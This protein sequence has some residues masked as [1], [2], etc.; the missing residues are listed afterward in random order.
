MKTNTLTT[1]YK[2]EPVARLVKRD[3]SGPLYRMLV[4]VGAIVIAFFCIAGFVGIVTDFSFSK[5]VE[6]IF[7]GVMG[8]KITTDSWLKDASFL[9]LIGLALAPAFKMKFWNI[10]AQGQVLVGALMTAI[11]MVNFSAA[12][13]NGS[14]ILVSFVLSILA[15]GIWALIPAFFKIKLNANETLFTLMLNYIAIQLVASCINMWRGQNSALGTLNP[16]TQSG[17]LPDMF[18]NPYGI[19]F[20]AAV[21]F[22]VLIYIYMYKTKHGYEISVV[23]ESINTARYAGINTKKVILRTMFLS[24]AIAGLCGF[25]YVAGINHSIA[26]NTGGSYGFTAIIVAWASKFNPFAM[27]AISLLIVFVEKGS[28]GIINA[29]KSLNNSIIYINVA[30]FLLFLIGCEFFINYKIVFNSRIVALIAKSKADIQKKLPKTCAFFGKTV[31]FFKKL[32]AKIQ[33]RCDEIAN[34]AE[35]LVKSAAL[36]VKDA[37]LKQKNKIAARLPHKSKKI[38]SKKEAE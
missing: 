29:E 2:R 6:L 4:R 9:L 26:A 15:G 8:T 31:N 20:F 23:G 12:L 34:H 18:G 33:D 22:M 11:A 30:I 13:D 19:V 35:R 36:P 14:L 25:I 16:S 24:G 7:D 5:I 37:I 27:A 3:D 28:G 38:S 21:L 1:E 32:N 17:Y 10:G